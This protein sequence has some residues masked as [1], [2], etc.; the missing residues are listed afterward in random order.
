[1]VSEIHT[2]STTKATED[3]IKRQKQMVESSNEEVNQSTPIASEDGT[4]SPS[5]SLRY[6]RQ[7]SPTFDH[8]DIFPILRD[9]VMPPE[10]A[11]YL[12]ST[13]ESPT[14]DS[15][16]PRRSQRHKAAIVE[17]ANVTLRPQASPSAQPSKLDTSGF[18]PSEGNHYQFEYDSPS[19]RTAAELNELLTIPARPKAFPQDLKGNREFGIAMSYT[20]LG[21]KPKPKL[22][23]KAVAN[24]EENDRLRKEQVE[25]E[26][27]KD[28]K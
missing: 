20:Y 19:G 15:D 14:R 9:V 17:A 5:N 2:P 12:S 8:S 11:A 28:D 4:R 6:R 25:E 16:Q 26:M 10:P 24:M 3:G 1:M 27:Q 13:I 21:T 22:A 23:Q 18:M 7:M